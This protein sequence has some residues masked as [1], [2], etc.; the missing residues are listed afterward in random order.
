M[1]NHR[2]K[3]IFHSRSAEKG[4]AGEVD[5]QIRNNGRL[6]GIYEGLR[7]DGVKSG[8][9]YEH[10]AKATVKYNPQGVKEVFVVAYVI[11]HS[12]GFGEFWRRFVDCVKKYEAYNPEHQI[13]WDDEVEDTGLSAVRSIHGTYDMD[14]EE[15]SVHIMAVKIME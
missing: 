8:E 12:T 7:L 4:H 14:D 10:I 15:H 2:Q 13:T 11:K 9:I 3:I 6:I 5:I 1:E